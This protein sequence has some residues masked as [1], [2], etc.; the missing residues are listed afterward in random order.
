MDTYRK[1]DD[2][3]SDTINKVTSFLSEIGYADPKVYPISAYAAQLGKQAIFEG[4]EDE[5]D[6]DSLKTFH[7]KLKKPEFS[8]YIYY[9]NEVDISEYENR[10]EY[11]L[12]KNSGIL[13]LEKMIYG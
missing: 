6:Q 13:H 11:A 9:P 3:I 8:Y 4:I 2:S 5:E 10:E 7:R 1:G 12:L